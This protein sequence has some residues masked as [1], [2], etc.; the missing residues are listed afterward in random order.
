MSYK[1]ELQNADKGYTYDQDKI[2][3]PKETVER[4]KDKLKTLDLDILSSTRR[5]DNGRLDIPIYFSECGA[6]A[7]KIIGTNKQMGKGGTPEQSEAS[8]VMELSERFSFFSF[9]K[10]EANFI[11][12]PPKKAGEKQIPYQ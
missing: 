5:I 2:I 12:S 6:D 1:I 7:K 3:S 10:D 8:A 11:S 9:V 4:V